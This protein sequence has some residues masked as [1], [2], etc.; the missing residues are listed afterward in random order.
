MPAPLTNLELL[1]PLLELGDGAP[2]EDA[3]E[4]DPFSCLALAWKASKLLGDD[5]LALTEKTMPWPQ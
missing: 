1:A 5:S 4:L 3:V 2:L